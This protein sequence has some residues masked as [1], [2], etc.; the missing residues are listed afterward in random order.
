MFNGKNAVVAIMIKP[1]TLW[2]EANLQKVRPVLPFVPTW[3]AWRCG[4]WCSC[5]EIKGWL[6]RAPHNMAEMGKGKADHKHCWFQ[7]VIYLIL[8]PLDKANPHLTDWSSSTLWCLGEQH[9]TVRRQHWFLQRLEHVVHNGLGCLRYPVSVDCSDRLGDDQ[10]GEFL[11]HGV[12][13]GQLWSGSYYDR[14]ATDLRTSQL[15]RSLP[16]TPLANMQYR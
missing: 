3:L 8:F 2:N 13:N 14:S 6:S 15:W 1:K 11:V 12:E 10:E 9:F 5:R 7:S 4:R 16:A